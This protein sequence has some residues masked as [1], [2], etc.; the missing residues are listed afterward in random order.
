MQL[1][2]MVEILGVTTTPM[3]MVPRGTSEATCNS[4]GVHRQTATPAKP[5]GRVGGHVTANACTGKEG[6]GGVGVFGG[7]AGGFTGTVQESWIGP[8]LG[9]KALDG[10]E[11]SPA[12]TT[13][14]DGCRTFSHPKNFGLLLSVADSGAQGAFRTS[15][16]R[17][18]RLCPSSFSGRATPW[19]TSSTEKERYHFTSSLNSFMPL[20]SRH[21][22]PPAG[23]LISSAQCWRAL[24]YATTF[25]WGIS[26]IS[27]HASINWAG[28][29][30]LCQQRHGSAGGALRSASVIP[31]S[32]ICCGSQKEAHTSLAS[33]LQSSIPGTAN[34]LVHQSGVLHFSAFH[35]THWLNSKTMDSGGILLP[36]SLEVSGDPLKKDATAS[37]SSIGSSRSELCQ[38]LLPHQTLSLGQCGSWEQ[39]VLKLHLAASPLLLFSTLSLVVP[40]LGSCPHFQVVPSVT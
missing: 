34:N 25:S 23:R 36:S 1:I 29:I 32:C 33:F 17:V 21:G 10:W 38:W 20:A 4:S 12:A 37:P 26:L 28:G 35:G 3:D 39:G 18:F 6:L 16:G 31:N 8:T 24:A 22:P 19:N 11:I 15:V 14:Q 30:N 7:E 2:L 40:T 9:L 27:L 13:G 5:H